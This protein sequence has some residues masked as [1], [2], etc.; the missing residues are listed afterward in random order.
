MRRERKKRVYGLPPQALRVQRFATSWLTLIATNAVTGNK[1]III[2][3]IYATRAYTHTSIKEG[4]NMRYTIESTSCR[5]VYKHSDKVK[6]SE[7]F[8][9]L[10]AEII[11]REELSE[12]RVVQ[13]YDDVLQWQRTN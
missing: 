10:L 1:P 12:N 7:R 8:T 6:R 4:E 9:E 2:G 5:N 3:Y 13:E 11:N